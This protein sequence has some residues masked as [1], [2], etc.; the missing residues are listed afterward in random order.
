MPLIASFT[1]RSRSTPGRASGHLRAARF[2]PGRTA[3]LLA[4]AAALAG[5]APES[6]PADALAQEPGRYTLVIG[7]QTH[8][9]PSFSAEGV[10]FVSLP[11]LA[12]GRSRLG[13]SLRQPI[14]SLDNKVIPLD[15]AT[16]ARLFEPFFT[17]TELGKGTRHGLST[18]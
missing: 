13:V 17:T 7:G 5:P 16:Q 9:L 1:A 14:A 18:V 11:T 3:V 15:A 6:R 12:I 2:A 8:T 4:A 10:D